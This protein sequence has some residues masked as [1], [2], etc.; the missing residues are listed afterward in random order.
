MINAN[1]GTATALMKRQQQSLTRPAAKIDEGGRWWQDWNALCED[2]ASR[3]IIWLKT[4][5]MKAATL[6]LVEIN[7]V[8]DAVEDEVGHGSEARWMARGTG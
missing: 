6:S 7:A 3:D 2:V 4:V 8:L 5:R 1:Y